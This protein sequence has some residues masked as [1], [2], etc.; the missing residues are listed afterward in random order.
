MPFTSRP[1]E[2]PPPDHRSEESRPIAR[3]MTET[4]NRSSWSSGQGK[5]SWEQ[6]RGLGG[7]SPSLKHPLTHLTSPSGLQSSQESQ[8]GEELWAQRGDKGSAD[9]LTHVA[10]VSITGVDKGINQ[11]HLKPPSGQSKGVPGS[12]PPLLQP[13][14]AG[15]LNALGLWHQGPVLNALGLWVS[16]N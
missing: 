11:D 12:Q 8:S 14:G 15:L 13:W 5:R 2:C 6:G 7:S 1:L 4:A 16:I 3:R 10:P 9:F